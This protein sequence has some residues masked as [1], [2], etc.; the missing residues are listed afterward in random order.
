MIWVFLDFFVGDFVNRFE[1]LFLT[2]ARPIF[3]ILRC[4][5]LCYTIEVVG[6][7]DLWSSVPLIDELL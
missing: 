2:S 4:L 5:K 6:G 1:I 3:R 7:K